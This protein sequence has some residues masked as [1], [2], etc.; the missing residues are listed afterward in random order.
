ML[1]SELKGNE[2]GFHA[3]IRSRLEELGLPLPKELPHIEGLRA[4]KKN[5]A[6]LDVDGMYGGFS[7]FFLSRKAPAKL[8]VESWSRI[9]GGSGQRHLVT[10]SATDL[11]EAGF[12]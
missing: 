1:E 4:T 8:I 9:I 5:P 12:V 11:V 7:Y 6:W 3:L 2:E 10:S